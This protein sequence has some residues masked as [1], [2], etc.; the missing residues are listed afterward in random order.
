MHRI[1]NAHSFFQTEEVFF[2]ISAIANLIWKIVVVVLGDYENCS[3]HFITKNF[4][5]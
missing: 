2:G 4:V 3:V 1:E 5:V